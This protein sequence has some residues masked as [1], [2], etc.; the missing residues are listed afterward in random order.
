MAGHWK[1]WYLGNLKIKGK[2]YNAKRIL[3][4]FYHRLLDKP[5]ATAGM[6]TCPAQQLFRISHC[7]F[8]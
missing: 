7:C 3:Q 5:I 4:N 2:S 8:K 6:P 1:I